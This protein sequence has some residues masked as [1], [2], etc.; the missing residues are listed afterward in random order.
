MER[1]IKVS[2]IVPVYNVEKFLHKCL[3]SI[4]NQDYRNLEIILINDGSTDHSREIL[5]E[6]SKKDIRIKIIHQEN[7]GVST[8]RNIG[9]DE[10]T[11]EYLCFADSDDFLE[12]DCVSYLLNLCLT[13]SA[14]VAL[15]TELSS[16]FWK[17]KANRNI[18]YHVVSGNH[19]TKMMLYYYI[20]IGCY[21]KMFKKNVLD[22]YKIRFIPNVY[23]GEGFNFNVDFFQRSKK[24]VIG[25]KKVYCYRR[26]NT[27]SAMTLFKID[28]C[29]IALEAI[30]ILRDRLIIRDKSVLQAVNYAFWHT[31]ADMYNWMVLAKSKKCY[32]HMYHFCFKEVW[33]YAYKAVLAPVNCKE[34]FRAILEIIHPKLLIFL[35]K[36]RQNFL[37][38]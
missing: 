17:F 15:S 33:S 19:A 8:A 11:G 31:C 26:N 30:K 28:K 22:K 12:K 25:N 34:R 1:S 38:R 9:I 16:T 29:E 36:F 32:P 3:D 2:I 37:S 5:E 13:S 24:V 21:C 7:K 4:I 18:R 10:A 20:P 14:D 23:I 35:I 27:N 6:Y